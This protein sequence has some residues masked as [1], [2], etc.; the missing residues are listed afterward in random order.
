MGLG[1]VVAVLALPAEAAEPRRYELVDG[2]RRWRAAKLAKLV[3]DYLAAAGYRHHWLA[4]GT[5]VADWVRE[6]QPD[7]VLLVPSQEPG[8][9]ASALQST[10][11]TKME[12]GVLSGAGTRLK[13]R[14]LNAV[15]RPDRSRFS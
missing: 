13:G 9:A 3:A 8:S 6:H 7:L 15:Q 11:V 4:E 1:L 5:G 12:R 14:V 2:E 10:A